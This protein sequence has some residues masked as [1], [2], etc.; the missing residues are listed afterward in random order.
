MVWCAGRQATRA[1]SSAQSQGEE[2]GC[3]AMLEAGAK[4]K[5]LWGVLAS[6]AGGHSVQALRHERLLGS[7]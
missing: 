4:L 1:A 7:P 6:G 2:A 5:E 3:V